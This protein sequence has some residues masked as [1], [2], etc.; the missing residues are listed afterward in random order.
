VPVYDEKMNSFIANDSEKV[1]S[2]LDTSITFPISEAFGIDKE[3]VIDERTVFVR[4]FIRNLPEGWKAS[5]EKIAMA[6]ELGI[7]LDKHQTLVDN[8]ERKIKT[9]VLLVIMKIVRCGYVLH[10]LRKC[11]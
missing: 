4:S 1:D 8:F 2:P 11:D 9:A 7:E 10:I 3:N 6:K 5:S